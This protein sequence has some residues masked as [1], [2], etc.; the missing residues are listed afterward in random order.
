MQCSVLRALEMSQSHGVRDESES[1]R[2]QQLLE[3]TETFWVS[4]GL[5]AP[6][7]ST[8][9]S[10]LSKQYSEPR[11]SSRCDGSSARLPIAGKTPQQNMALCR[12]FKRDWCMMGTIIMERSYLTVTQIYLSDMLKKDVDPHRKTPEAGCG[13]WVLC[14]LRS[15]QQRPLW[16]TQQLISRALRQATFGRLWQNIWQKE[17]K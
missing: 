9:K 17:R 11:T 7:R 2:V 16:F 8:H 3:I 1:Q 10:K 5:V 15:Y 14:P 6:K 4:E 12:A 13:W